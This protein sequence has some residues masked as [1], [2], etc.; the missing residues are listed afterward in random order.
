MESQVNKN[1]L[2]NILEF[3]R[4]ENIEYQFGKED[5]IIAKMNKN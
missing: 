4:K 3:L 1:E 5:E 2:I